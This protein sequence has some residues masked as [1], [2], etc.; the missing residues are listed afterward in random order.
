MTTKAEMAE[1]E[2]QIKNLLLTS[3]LSKR[4]IAKQLNTSKDVVYRV[5]HSIGAVRKPKELPTVQRSKYWPY[6]IINPVSKATK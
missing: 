6:Q 1:K 3:S 4:E 2:K 5:A